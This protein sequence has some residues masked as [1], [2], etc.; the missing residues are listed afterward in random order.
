MDILLSDNAYEFTGGR[1]ISVRDKA[2]SIFEKTKHCTKRFP[3]RLKLAM[4]MFSAAILVSAVA[5]PIIVEMS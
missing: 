1:T 4:M 3:C 5:V 2:M